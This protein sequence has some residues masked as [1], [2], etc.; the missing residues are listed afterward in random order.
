MPMPPYLT[1]VGEKQNLITQGCSTL[2]SIGNNYQIGRENQIL[3]ESFEHHFRR[4]EGAQSGGRVHGPVTITKAFDKAT[5][6]IFEAW[7]TGE[8]LSVCTLDWYRISPNGF[9]EHFY[10]MVFKD[11]VITDIHV[12]MPHW[13]DPA[14]AH[15]TQLES[16]TFAYRTITSTH[17]VCGTMG[18]DYW[19][20][21]ASA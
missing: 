10:T 18:S 12:S 17:E 11:A 1:L 19:R 8:T 7:R 9:Q 14:F 20:D 3:V 5:P 16:V 4:P 13:R 6:L 21:G 2:E 15:V